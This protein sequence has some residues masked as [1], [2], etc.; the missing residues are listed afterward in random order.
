MAGLAVVSMLVGF[1]LFKSSMLEMKNAGF[2]YGSI[3]PP[4]EGGSAPKPP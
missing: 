3:V 1:V 2:G 4:T